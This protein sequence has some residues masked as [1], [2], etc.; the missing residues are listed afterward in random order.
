MVYIESWYLACDND[1]C[2]AESQDTG[3]ENDARKWAKEN[4][5]FFGYWGD[6]GKLVGGV[7]CPKHK[8]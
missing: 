3:D 7:K 1:D 4:G 8:E 2:D 5:W 6:A